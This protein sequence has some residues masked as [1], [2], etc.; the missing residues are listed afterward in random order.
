[1]KCRNCNA[2]INSSS[3]IC[4]YC[5]TPFSLKE[6]SKYYKPEE[7]NIRVKLKAE[8]SEE[9]IFKKWGFKQSLAEIFAFFV[10]FG[11]FNSNEVDTNEA[12]DFLLLCYAL[13]IF[14]R[15]LNFIRYFKLFGRRFESLITKITTFF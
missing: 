2:P 1:M 9:K 11:L 10:L 3:G 4:E 14:V 5:N 13:L 6:V 12:Q 15:F 8:R 7:N